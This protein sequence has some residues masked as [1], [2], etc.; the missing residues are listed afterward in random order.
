M[1]T[2]R[3]VF[4]VSYF[5]DRL[6]LYKEKNMLMTEANLA[7]RHGYQMIQSERK[8]KVRKS[9]G[10][11]KHV[12]GERKRVKLADFRAY[13]EELAK[14]DKL[15]ADKM[16]DEMQT[17]QQS[18]MEESMDDEAEKLATNDKI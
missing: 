14:L 1:H 10:A 8:R 16:V 3:T 12:L 5:L 13:K 9:M 7:R 2:E 18:E 4:A 6:V 15:L 17:I 11:I